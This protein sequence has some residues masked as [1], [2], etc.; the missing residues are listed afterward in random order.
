MVWGLLRVQESERSVNPYGLH[1]DALRERILISLAHKGLHDVGVAAATRPHYS[2]GKLHLSTQA[3][4]TEPHIGYAH[5]G[6]N[7]YKT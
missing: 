5:L 7:H 6:L 1:R 2:R 4:S 3:S